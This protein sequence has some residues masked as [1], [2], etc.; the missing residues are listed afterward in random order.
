MNLNNKSKLRE[1]RKEEEEEE[2]KEEEEDAWNIEYLI[3]HTT[4]RTRTYIH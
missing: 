4:I 2:E 3:S 1:G